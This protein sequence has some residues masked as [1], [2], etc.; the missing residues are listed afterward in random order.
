[1][2]DCLDRDDGGGVL[3]PERLPRKGGSVEES[4]VNET[5][6]QDHCESTTVKQVPEQRNEYQTEGVRP[7][8]G[9][10]PLL[11]QPE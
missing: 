8:H 5:R 9:T 1:M 3:G 11:G 4:T 10:L 2:T 7:T 6:E